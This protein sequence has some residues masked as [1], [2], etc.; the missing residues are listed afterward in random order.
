MRSIGAQ[1]SLG[2]FVGARSIVNSDRFI[3]LALQ[4]INLK[5]T[6]TDYRYNNE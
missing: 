2:D 3:N 1:S 5:W 6:V 4:G